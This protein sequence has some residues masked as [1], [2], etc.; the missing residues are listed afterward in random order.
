MALNKLKILTFIL[1]IGAA[2]SVSTKEIPKNNNL[3]ISIKQLLLTGQHQQALPLIITLAEQGHSQA[4]Y[5][6]A[7]FYL[8]GN[9]VNKSTEKAEYW[10]LRASK[11]N[12][13]AS[14]LIGSLYAQGKGLAKNL[15]KA[16]TLLALSKKQGN[17]K[18]KQL[19]DSLFISSNGLITP[20]QLQTN[21]IKAIKSGSLANVIKLYQQG[22]LLTFV[23]TNI[24]KNTPLLTALKSHQKEIALWIIKTI[25]SQDNNHQ[26]NNADN[27][28]NTA[29]HI[30]VQNNL[31]QET[32]LLIRVKAD[33]NAV[34]LKN[35][36]PLILA[37]IA[38]NRSIA[39]QLINQGAQLTTKDL[40]G[41]NALHYANESDLTLVI[42]SPENKQTDQKQAKQTLSNK[43]QTLKVQATNK[44]SPYYAW[45]ILTIA[46]AQKQPLLIDE[47]LRLKHSAWQDNPQKDNAISIAIKQEQSKLAVELL[48]HSDKTVNN[49]TA[50]EQKQLSNL[51]AT[52]IKH[53]DLR[54]IN[55]LLLLTN[56]QI[57]QKLPIEET[58]L[59]FAIKFKQADAFLEVAKVIPPDNRL[60]KQQRSYLLLASEF[61]LTKITTFLLSM[62]INVNLRNDAGRSALWY[63]A[64]SANIKLI[65]RLI[66]AKSNITQPDNLGHTPLMR[67][68]INNCQACVTSLLN[69][70]AN[71]QKQTVNA[72]SAL[73]FAAQGKPSILK[74]ILNFNHKA[75]HGEKLNIK[76]RN[77]N[78]LTPLMLAIK[79]NCTQC[80][81]YLLDAGANPKRKNNQNENSFDLAESKAD[82]LTLLK[83]H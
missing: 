47:L 45:P 22:A 55:R 62:D 21:L 12:K 24:S 81:K 78:S 38:K 82:I 5:Q 43:L 72:N 13:K 41:K 10:L 16:K 39:Q 31:S 17:S 40:T 68:V 80:V 27:A 3:P 23:P 32:S 50:N 4:Q 63:A 58:P 49:L 67:A 48:N 42:Q 8:Q 65:N 26:Y 74:I 57:L 53:N 56:T 33:I 77:S 61:N 54:L 19:Y 6:L 79:S 34:N 44:K 29:L 37:V 69:A 1:L 83:K 35:Q 60:D 14:Y 59:W 2:Y 30:A 76:Q 28:G 9:T 73:L 51:F 36:T 70:G 52:A 7:L 15:D 25:K 66:Y 64:N 75:K 71:V 20:T 18:A 46:V 11:S